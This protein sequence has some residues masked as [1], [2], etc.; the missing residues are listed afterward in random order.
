[1]TPPSRACRAHV[2]PLPSDGRQE[3]LSRN[4]SRAS[5]NAP[6]P[7]VILASWLARAMYV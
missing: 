7:K 1:M 3:A 2:P 5:A 6:V 4:G